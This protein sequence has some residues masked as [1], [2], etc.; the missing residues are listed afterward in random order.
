MHSTL[1]N[2]V[3]RAW[4]EEQRSRFKAGQASCV[5]ADDG[6]RKEETPCSGASHGGRGHLGDFETLSL[7]EP[8][9]RYQNAVSIFQKRDGGYAE[10]YHTQ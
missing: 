10:P 1:T 2:A 8:H 9:K 5:S 3:T 6:G 4:L 7:L